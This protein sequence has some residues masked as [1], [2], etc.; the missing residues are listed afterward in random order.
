MD[1][2]GRSVASRL[3]RLPASLGEV[4]ELEVEEGP[5][6]VLVIENIPWNWS[7]QRSIAKI[8]QLFLRKG[9]IQL[10]GVDASCGDLE[11]L[12]LREYP[13]PEVRNRTA[14]RFLKSLQLSGPEYCSIVNPDKSLVVCSLEEP[15]LLDRARALWRSQSDRTFHPLVGPWSSPGITVFA[16]LEARRSAAMIGHL[17]ERFARHHLTAAALVCGG[18]L[19]GRI[20]QELQRRRVSR[21]RVRPRASGPDDLERYRRRILGERSPLEKVLA[22]MPKKPGEPTSAQDWSRHL[23]DGANMLRQQAEA[24]APLRELLSDSRELLSSDAFRALS[25]DERREVIAELALPFSLLREIIPPAELAAL[26]TPEET[27]F[28][29]LEDLLSHDNF[30]D[31]ADFNSR[32]SDLLRRVPDPDLERLLR[33]PRVALRVKA[34]LRRQLMASGKR[35]WEVERALTAVD[36]PGLSGAEPDADLAPAGD[37]ALLRDLSAPNLEAVVDP[38][39]RRCCAHLAAFRPGCEVREA[40]VA[41]FWERT[42]GLDETA[43]SHVLTSLA[44]RS[45]L[46]LQGEPPM[47]RVRLP[48]RV[49]GRLCGAGDELSAVHGAL[50]EAYA[51]FCAQG[52]PKGPSDG[53]FF[54]NLAFHLIEAGRTDELCALLLDH[55]WLRAKVK[56]AGVGALLDDYNLALAQRAFAPGDPRWEDLEG[57]RDALRLSSHALVRDESQL[58]AQLVGRLLDH[59]SPGIQALLSQLAHREET[60]WLRP[61]SAC[62]VAAGGPLVCALKGHSAAVNAVALMPDGRRAITGSDDRTLKLWDLDTGEMLETLRGPAAPVHAV[63]IAGAGERAISAGGTDSPSPADSALTIWDLDSRSAV[64]SLSGC[65]SQVN[66]VAVTPDGRLALCA[67]GSH[68][69]MVRSETAIRAF[70]LQTGRPLFALE[71]HTEP[72]NAVVVTPDGRR[73]VSG[74]GRSFRLTGPLDQGLASAFKVLGVELPEGGLPAD[75]K[76]DSTIRVWDLE[77][78]R[79]VRTLPGHDGAVR[80]LAALPDARRVL[81]CGD[82]QALK[83]WDLDKGDLLAALQGRGGRLFAVAVSPDGKRAFSGSDQ[84]A[85]ELWDLE[86]KERVGLVAAHGA[87]IK[88]LAV[89]ADGRRAISCSDDKTAKVWDLSR[90]KREDSA[91]RR[92][93]VDRLRVSADGKYAVCASQ[94]MPAQVWDVARRVR[95]HALAG[96]ESISELLIGA[97]ALVVGGSPDGNL[98]IWS[99]ESGRHRA[100][101]SGHS[102]EIRHLAAGGERLVSASADGVLCAWD[103][104][105]LKR[106]RAWT[107][108]ADLTRLVVTPDGRRVICGGKREQ[109]SLWDLERGAR[110]SSFRAG[111]RTQSD[112]FIRGLTV[113]CDGRRLVTFSSNGN[114]R[115]FD[116]PDL[117][118]RCSMA[119]GGI[120]SCVAVSP[121]GRRAVASLLVSMNE[122]GELRQVGQSPA[123]WDLET[124][125]G[126]LA[127]DFSNESA[128]DIVFAPGGQRA[129]AILGESVAVFDL[130]SGGSARLEL[131]HPLRSCA[132]A[133]NGETET[134]IVGDAA[135][136]VHFIRLSG[137]FP[138]EE[139]PRAERQERSSPMRALPALERVSPTQ[140]YF[141]ARCPECGV[142]SAFQARPKVGSTLS[143][144]LFSTLA[145][146]LPSR[147]LWWLILA[148]P[149]GLLALVILLGLLVGDLRPC[150]ACGKEVRPRGASAARLPSTRSRGERP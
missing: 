102:A 30:A 40:V 97:G 117:R 133:A 65:G 11:A 44:S 52:W 36:G 47:R 48:D 147:S 38:L 89:A 81:S 112:N 71:G 85:I 73:A 103:L 130:T 111:A 110:L 75:A 22:Q 72:V 127:L 15:E 90:V 114:L 132:V 121:D 45:L 120:P 59:R 49:D 101:L 145:I 139:R 80:G 136:G 35:G 74:S 64:S 128:S 27:R 25:A 70:D 106:T 144:L 19:P 140:R 33:S 118:E 28:L 9:F 29:G 149:T 99:I 87:T 113:T 50:L 1:G 41:R 62:L 66:S 53:Y 67:Q 86:S 37:T 61:L 123:V 134:M 68:S 21:A 60:P 2:W 46:L 135:G 23:E 88:G 116:L 63:A 32:I 138:V 17:Q 143:L 43:A 57:V 16:D 51:T 108:D 6:F 125:E 131:D 100:T 82:D 78:P 5:G 8:L 129:V 31:L 84:G 150:P 142:V 18:N 93:S 124:G 69:P 79:A 122:Q 54:Q 10:V 24:G 42:A 76:P 3:R 34:E 95:L 141:D 12:C 58:P 98:K 104:E 7:A 20:G 137:A 4:L 109:L 14:L 77:P 94:G 92:T 26:L 119:L 56:D 107:L 55:R 91:D 13:V 126:P 146:G 96:S 39:E 83:L 105:A 148:I 115:V